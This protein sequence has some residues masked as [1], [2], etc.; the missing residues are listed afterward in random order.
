MV[1][2]QHTMAIIHRNEYTHTHTHIQEIAF[3]QAKGKQ[4]LYIY[5]N[6]FVAS[7]FSCFVLLFILF[8]HV[9]CLL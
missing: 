6:L 2:N 7:V 1:K 5:F 3:I 9:C 8:N 4:G